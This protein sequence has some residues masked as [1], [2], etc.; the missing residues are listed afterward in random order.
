MEALFQAIARGDRSAVADAVAKGIDVNRRDPIGRTPLQVAILSKSIDVAC[1]L[2]DVGARMA[3]TVVDGRNAL[4]FAAQAGL[5]VVAKKLLDRSGVNA[6]KEKA[7]EAAAESEDKK[8]K[9]LVINDGYASTPDAEGELNDGV[10]ADED[11]DAPD[12][13]EIDAVDWDYHFSALDYAVASGSPPVLEVLLAAGA[14]PGLVTIPKHLASLEHIHPLALTATVEEEEKANRIAQMLIA[15][16]AVTTGADDTLCT[17]LHRV[18]AAGHPSLVST[19]LKYDAKA[20]TVLNVPQLTYCETLFPI[21]TA[22]IRGS[23]AVLAVL[24]AHGASIVITRDE[25]QRGREMK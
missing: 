5:H 4:H 9:S 8:P 1:D 11:S 13:L 14:N 20:M 22:V 19:F 21:V 7:K 16:G 23:Y 24:L 12:V 10:I 3:T 2:I 6:E 18:V 25:F 17:I 15:A